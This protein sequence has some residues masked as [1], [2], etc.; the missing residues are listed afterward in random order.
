MTLFY[1]AKMRPRLVE[2]PTLMSSVFSPFPEEVYQNKPCPWNLIENIFPAFQVDVVTNGQLEE[3]F[4]KKTLP[5][6]TMFSLPGRS[7]D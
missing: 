6:E 5:I 3:L 7:C 2:H 1:R 4:I